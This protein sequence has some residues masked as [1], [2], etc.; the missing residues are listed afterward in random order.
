MPSISTISIVVVAVVV[1]SV[2]GCGG[3]E[4]RERFAR[5]DVT[6]T[7]ESAGEPL[8]AAPVTRFLR[9]RGVI[10]A[11]HGAG[12]NRTGLLVLIFNRRVAQPESRCVEDT[13]CG[14]IVEAVGN[15]LVSFNT[16]LAPNAGPH[17]RRVNAAVRSL[18]QQDEETEP[19]R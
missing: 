9:R 7:F 15:I 12:A 6:K 3:G 4:G 8:S 17:V 1:L 2:T 14:E 5:S 18:R 19:V 10:S 16:K 11:F 13:D